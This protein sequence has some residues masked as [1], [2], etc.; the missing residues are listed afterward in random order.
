MSNRD[1]GFVALGRFLAVERYRETHLSASMSRLPG[2]GR[3]RTGG[4]ADK[5][6]SR[7][8]SQAPA[9]RRHG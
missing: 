5:S 2:P 7:S 3:D 8:G 9:R 4:Y 1:F 6:G